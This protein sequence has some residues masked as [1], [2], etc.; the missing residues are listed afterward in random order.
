[1]TDSLKELIMEGWADD[2]IFLK[3]WKAITDEQ[4]ELCKQEIII[5]YYKKGEV[6]YREGE[7]PRLL[8]CLLKGKLKIYKEGLA[9]AHS[10][11]L[12]IVHPMS[13]FGYR[14][15][16]AH[17]DYAMSAIA[18]EDSQVLSLPMSLVLKLMAENEFMALFLL[19]DM[20]REL[21]YIDSRIMSLT[22]KHV[23]GRLAET[24]LTMEK[25]FGVDSEGNISV[26][27]SREDIAS[28][29]NMTTNNA[30]RTLSAFANEG[31]VELTGKHIR[32]VNSE[33]LENVSKFE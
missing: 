29:S 13:L 10:Q 3:M 25:K 28:F 30:I 5:K 21:G 15:F 1:M 26:V 11:I 14:A 27:M 33:M 20:A 7:M 22:Q 12:H 31:L 6:I 24:L 32:L 4:R 16:F 19:Q 23:R 17:E 8:L 2:K 9:G 18:L